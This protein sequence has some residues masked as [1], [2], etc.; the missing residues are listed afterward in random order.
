[1]LEQQEKEGFNLYQTLR[2]PFQATQATTTVVFTLVVLTRPSTPTPTQTLTLTPS[3]YFISND[4]SKEL[5]T[6][7]R[8]YNNKSK[9]TGL[10]N[11]F[12]YK[13]DIFHNLCS[14]ASVLKT[15]KAKAYLTILTSLALNHYYTNLCN[16][17][18][19]FLFNQLYNVTQNYF[20]GPKHRR[21][22]LNK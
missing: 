3:P 21:L 15:A 7:I 6:L 19:T 18:Q 11:N 5:I 17:A 14:Q 12:D 16:V 22:I 4:S 10:N 2:P 20:K 9:Y 13:L 1:M 8:I